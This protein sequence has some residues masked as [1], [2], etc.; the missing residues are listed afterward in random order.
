MAKSDK[1]ELKRAF[2]TDGNLGEQLGLTKD[3]VSRIVKAVGNYGEVL[4]SQRRRRLQARHCPRP[5]QALEQG[6]YPVRA[7]DPLIASAEGCGDGHRT[8]KTTVA[9]SSQAA[10]GARRP[11]GLERLC[12]SSSCSSPRS[13]GSAYEIVANARANLQAQ[14]ITAGFGFLANTAGFDVSQSLIPY[15]GSDHLHPRLP[16]RPAQYAAGLG[17]RHLLRHPDRISS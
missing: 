5:Q 12:R 11:G 7:A 16:G 14:R 3:W 9:A 8:P 10:A 4:R 6:R 2:G 15:S 17:D 13:P 1:P